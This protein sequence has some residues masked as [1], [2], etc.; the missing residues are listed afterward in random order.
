[1]KSKGGN[2]TLERVHVEVSTE[3]IGRVEV[4]TEFIGSVEVDTESIGTAPI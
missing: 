3:S 4:S 1:M 2:E